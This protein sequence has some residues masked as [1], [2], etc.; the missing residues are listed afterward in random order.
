MC[1]CKKQMY[2]VYID[3]ENRDSNSASPSNFKYTINLPRNNNFKKVA[4]LQCEFPKSYYMLDTSNTPS[5][6]FTVTYD[7]AGTPVVFA[8]SI[9]GNRVYTADQLATE[10]QTQLNADNGTGDVYT[11]T[12]SDT[13]GKFTFTND[14]GDFNFV[15]TSAGGDTSLAKYLGFDLGTTYTSIGF[16]LTSANVVNLQRYNSLYLRSN[17]VDEGRNGNVLQEMFMRNIADFDLLSINNAHALNWKK[18]VQMDDQTY[19]FVITDKDNKAVEL[20]GGHV[21]L[22]LLFSE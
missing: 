12:F 21:C 19:D 3:S 22:S 13:T 7:P 20:N 9:T 1:D 17:I 2:S 11:V 16:S 5:L 4:V 14:T 15:F 10:L 8:C 18:C 6:D